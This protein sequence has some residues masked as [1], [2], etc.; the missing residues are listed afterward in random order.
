MGNVDDIQNIQVSIAR[1][2]ASV[3]D[4]GNKI[5]EL[6]ERRTDCDCTGMQKD[7]DELRKT[8][9]MVYHWVNGDPVL[10][11][12]N[13]RTQVNELYLTHQRLKWTAALLGIVT[14][15]TAIGV[16]NFILGN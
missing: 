14:G 7:I 9:E 3:G 2:S 13:I 15:G 1:I 16:L 8:V 6:E 10:G 11:V 4:L 12:P 5:N